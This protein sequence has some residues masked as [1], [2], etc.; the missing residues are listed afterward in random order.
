[1]TRDTEAVDTPA[2]RATSASRD[3]P[4]MDLRVLILGQRLLECP[5]RVLDELLSASTFEVVEM[6]LQV[7]PGHLTSGANTAGN[8]LLCDTARLEL[9]QMRALRIDTCNEQPDTTRNA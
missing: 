8:H 5:Q 9:E 4:A 2:W 7:R 1:M 3:G 6:P